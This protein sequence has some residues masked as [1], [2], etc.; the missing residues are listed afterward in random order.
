MFARA[1]AVRVD[2]LQP[3]H[4]VQG[5]PDRLHPPSCEDVC[6]ARMGGKSARK[7]KAG[8]GSAAADDDALLDAAIAENKAAAEKQQQGTTA[9]GNKEPPKAALT[10]EQIIYKLNTVPTFCILNGQKNIVGLQDPSDPTGKLETCC[11][12]ADAAEAKATLAAAKAASPDV[13]S[14]LH[15]GVTPLGVAFDAC[16][17]W[18]HLV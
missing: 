4:E 14:Q 10:Q 8:G 18:A 3:P 15:L 1:G 17:G 13:A 6:D 16:S 7:A 12:F 9:G 5:R 2:S 11:W